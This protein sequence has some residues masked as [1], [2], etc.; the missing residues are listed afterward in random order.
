MLGKIILGVLLAV[1]LL[2]AVLL[3]IPVKVRFSYSQGDM[4]LSVCYG[5]I[6][7]PLFPL[8]KKDPDAPSKKKK[9]SKT[10]KEK[11]AK[12]KAKINMEQI[13]YSL[14]TLPSILGRALRRTGRGVRI[15][16]MKVWLLVAGSDP[17]DAALL[18][19]RLSA[20]LGAGLPALEQAVRIQDPDV[21]LF[22][23]FTEERMDCIA[24]VGIAL[25]PWTLAVA[26]VRAL[27]SLLKWFLRFRKLASPSLEPKEENTCEAA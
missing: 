26:G 3:L 16:P 15:S 4:A 10:K 14:E 12:P 1:P 11:P 23:D 19:G 22:L 24:E 7:I 17:A 2:M 21:R 8:R 25:R 20:A 27:G 9:P 5:P 18:Y 6:K 13:L